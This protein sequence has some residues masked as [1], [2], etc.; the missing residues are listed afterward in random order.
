MW[1]FIEECLQ[2]HTDAA[3]FDREERLTYDQLLEAARLHG[4]NLKARLPQGA[5]CALLCRRGLEQAIALL[6]CWYAG[7]VPI[8]LSLHYGQAHCDHILSLTKP[9]CIILDGSPGRDDLPPAYHLPDRQFSGTPEPGPP[10]PELDAVAVTLCTSSTTGLPKGAMITGQGLTANVKNIAAY[11]AIGPTD[12]ILLAR[13]LYHCAVLTGEFLVSLYKGLDICFFDDKYNPA[14]L[15]QSMDTYGITVLCGTPTLF[16]HLSVFL[17][18]KGQTG[19]LRAAAISGECL[20]SENARGIRKAFPRTDFYNVY[21]L[22]EAAPRVAYLPPSCF[23]RYPDAVGRPIRGAEVKI[24]DPSDF[25][26]E[27]PAGQ[28]GL[29]FIHSESL[30]KGYYQN[31]ALTGKVLRD[32]WLNSGDVGYIGENGFLYILSRYDDMII[33]GGLNIYPKEVENAIGRLDAVEDCL[34]YGIPAGTGQAVAADVVLRREAGQISQKELL[35]QI[36]GVLPEYQLPTRLRIVD[37]I[38]RNASGKAVRPR[39]GRFPGQ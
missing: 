15:L 37:A 26:R 5:K 9:A 19:R 13:P 8:P 3:L 18:R 12:T 11:F 22:T 35:R 36:A 7:L 2:R 23:D 24:T 6:A 20:S 29:I 38:G 31:P 28:A 27:Q 4:E 32:G 16:H 34:V 14:K 33:K 10:E 17:Q 21:G 30:M 25:S 1:P 39:A